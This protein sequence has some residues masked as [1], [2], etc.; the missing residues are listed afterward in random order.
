MPSHF[1]SPSGNPDVMGS[2]QGAQRHLVR[3]VNS[4]NFIFCNDYVSHI[5]EFLNLSRAAEM[6]VT[7]VKKSKKKSLEVAP[8]LIVKRSSP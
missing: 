5:E 4:R 7:N 1:S 8:P 6:S 3:R 2:L